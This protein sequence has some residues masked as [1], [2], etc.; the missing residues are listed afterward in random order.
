[1]LAFLLYYRDWIPL[2]FA[3]GVIAVHHL[4]FDAMQRAGLPVWVFGANGGVGIVVVHAAFVVFETA[5]LV[6]MAVR[7]KAEIE[8]VGCDPRELSKVAQQLAHGNLTVNIR[9]MGSP[10][11]LAHAMELMRSELE[12]YLERERANQRENHQIRTALDR[13]T[14]GAML[15]DDAGKIV[16]V[17]EHALEIFR[18]RAAEIRRHLPWFDLQHLIGSRFDDLPER[19]RRTARW[20]NSPAATRMN[21]TWALRCFASPPIP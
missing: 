16:Y 13:V 7:L 3:A 2:V 4:A 1:M 10:D 11:S 5:L 19:P 20:R 17:N 18:T 15:V 21:S 8:A 14:V 9:T 6:W 12:S